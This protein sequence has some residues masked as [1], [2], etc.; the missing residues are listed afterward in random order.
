VRLA[1]EL[2]PLDVIALG[3][4]GPTIVHGLRLAPPRLGAYVVVQGAGP[5][6]IAAAVLARASGA[7]AVIMVGGPAA[8]L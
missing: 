8:R 5:V 6:G 2:D 7:G 1:D 3:C 4:A